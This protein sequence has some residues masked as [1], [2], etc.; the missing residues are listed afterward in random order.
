MLTIVKRTATIMNRYNQVIRLTRGTIW[1]KTHTRKH[2]TQECQVV[3]PF[4][5]VDH[6]A[7]HT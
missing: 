5:A 4:P 2:N 6:K 3:S 1:Q 7:R